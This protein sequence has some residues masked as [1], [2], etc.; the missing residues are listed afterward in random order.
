MARAAL[1]VALVAL[2]VG[3]LTGYLVAQDQDGPRGPAGP[4]GSR[5]SAG[6]AGASA[7]LP[8][9]SVVLVRGFPNLTASCPTGLSQIGVVTLPVGGSPVP[10]T[11]CEV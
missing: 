2:V 6:V 3:P 4:A 7:S 5:G 1:V 8:N 9:G 10:F 11:L